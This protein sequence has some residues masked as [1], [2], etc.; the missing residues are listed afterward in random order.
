MTGDAPYYDKHKSKFVARARKLDPS[1]LAAL[2]IDETMLD[3]GDAVVTLCGILMDSTDVRPWTG[4]L[5]EYFKDVDYE[6][7]QSGLATSASGDGGVALRAWT[8]DIKRDGYKTY[9]RRL[10]GA[11]EYDRLERALKED[12]AVVALAIRRAVRAIMPFAV[13]WE[14]ALSEVISP[15]FM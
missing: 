4:R 2:R 7:V 5:D 10:L 13:A 3:V 14:D 12:A 11:A 9:A 8:D 15:V 1:L 6:E